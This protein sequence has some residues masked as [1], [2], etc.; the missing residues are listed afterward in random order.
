VRV[1]QRGRRPGLRQSAQKRQKWQALLD[2][3]SDVQGLKVAQLLLLLL[4]VVAV[5]HGSP[6]AGPT[7]SRRGVLVLVK[8]GGCGCLCSVQQLRGRDQAC[9]AE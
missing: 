1:G 7:N 8:E 9:W 5:S 6:A 3:R 2:V 4:L